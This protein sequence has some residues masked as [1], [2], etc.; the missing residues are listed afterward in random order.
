MTTKKT[1][2]VTEQ[3]ALK[4][5]RSSRFDYKAA[6]N[7][8]TETEALAIVV[9]RM[10]KAVLA[11]GFANWKKSGLSNSKRGMRVLNRII[12][13]ELG[14]REAVGVLEAKQN[15]MYSV[16]VKQNKLSTIKYKAMR[17]AFLKQVDTFV[18]KGIKAE[19][20][21]AA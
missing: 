19:A 18:A 14:T 9:N 5:L 20:K 8:A 13:A 1:L 15:F 12:P 21:L 2:S 6:I 7:K 4:A 10:D 17:D 11:G 16:C 3:I